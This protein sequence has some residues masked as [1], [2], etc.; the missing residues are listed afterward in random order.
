M[1]EIGEK[2]YGGIVVVVT[3]EN[4]LDRLGNVWLIVLLKN[5]SPIKK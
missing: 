2:T 3:L 5:V 1:N 4:L